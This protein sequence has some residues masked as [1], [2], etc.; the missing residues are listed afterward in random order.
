MAM[1]ELMVLDRTVWRITKAV[2]SCGAPISLGV[3]SRSSKKQFEKMVAAFQK[4][5]IKSPSA[6]KKTVQAVKAE[7]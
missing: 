1:H 6:R 4:R 5:K 2:C 7:G 3:D